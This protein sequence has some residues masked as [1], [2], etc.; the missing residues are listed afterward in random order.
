[1]RIVD[2]TGRL[3]RPVM[4]VNIGDDDFREQL[5]SWARTGQIPR[6]WREAEGVQE[7]ELT[8]EER[9][10]DARFQLALVLL[11]RDDKD[12]ALEQ[13]RAAV[14]LD[15]ENWLIR[16]QMW[17]VET[18]EAFYDGP[19]DFAWQ[20]AQREREAETLLKD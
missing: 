2:E 18:P 14:K 5:E 4:G 9:E 3:V 11:E 7:R 20:S 10:A 17:A 19:V 1:M 16:K 13:L 12:E 6:A 8:P 15:P